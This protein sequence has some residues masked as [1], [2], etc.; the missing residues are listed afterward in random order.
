MTGAQARSPPMA[1]PL[2]RGDMDSRFRGDDE[3]PAPPVPYDESRCA[4]KEGGW[5]H[6]V[7]C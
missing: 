3:W 4:T 7:L 6:D 5:L 1:P 2:R